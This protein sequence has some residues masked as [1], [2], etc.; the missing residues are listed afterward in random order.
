MMGD[1]IFLS[2]PARNTQIQFKWQT[3]YTTESI[4][5]IS[6][7]LIVARC[8]LMTSEWYHVGVGQFY[9]TKMV[10]DRYN[11]VSIYLNFSRGVAY[12]L[13]PI[14]CCMRVQSNVNRVTCGGNEAI[15]S[16]MDLFDMKFFCVFIC[17]YIVISF[18]KYWSHHNYVLSCENT[19]QSFKRLTSI[20]TKN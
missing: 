2:F 20:F 17:F 9:A 14:R 1:V 18:H 11:V 16:T 19:M 8:K 6:N 7:F 12:P 3:I 5:L 15:L 4:K 13:V 10:R